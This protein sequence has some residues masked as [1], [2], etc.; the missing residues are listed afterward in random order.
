[1]KKLIFLTGLLWALAPG[2]ARAVDVTYDKAHSTFTAVGVNCTTGTVVDLAPANSGGMIITAIR[3]Q[4]QDSADSVWLG[5]LSV[6]TS[7]VSGDSTANLGE[8]LA[9][10]SPGDS[11]VWPVGYDS[12]RSALIEIG[13]RAADAA[14]ANGVML[15]RVT[16]GYY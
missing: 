7:T 5:N 12:K 6:S 15:N 14:G 8:Q 4:N 9:G 10:G 11:V 16:F 13:C 1:M 3:F 2:K